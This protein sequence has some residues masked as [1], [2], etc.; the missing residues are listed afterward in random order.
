MNLSQEEWRER[1]ASSENATIID[2][3]TPE[4]W[5]EG[6]IPGAKKLNIFNAPVFM[7][8]LDTLDRS[9]E[10]FVYCR[11]GN[12]SGQACQIMASKGIEKAYNLLGGVMEWESDLVIE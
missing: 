2:V 7:A 9:Q 3:R 4:E 12:R 11:S 1:L 5:E 6:I 10:Y 8:E